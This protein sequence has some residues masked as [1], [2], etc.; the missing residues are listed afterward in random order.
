MN[1]DEIITMM[2]KIEGNDGGF[3]YGRGGIFYVSDEE[4]LTALSNEINA[5][6][7][8]K[9]KIK[10][11]PYISMTT[12]A[13]LFHIQLDRRVLE[14]LATRGISTKATREA[15]AND[16]GPFK[17]TDTQTPSPDKKPAVIQYSDKEVKAAH[18]IVGAAYGITPEQLR[19]AITVYLRQHG[20][21]A[22]VVNDNTPGGGARR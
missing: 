20:K 19:L 14:D 10:V 17:D 21:T 4:T 1:K 12:S 6:T 11:I 7:N 3:G 9:F 22:V 18:E 15:L 16:Q 5:L 13:E 8:N 2:Q